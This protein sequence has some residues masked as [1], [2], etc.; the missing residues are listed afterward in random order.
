MTEPERLTLRWE[1]L[2]IVIDNRGQGARGKGIE[3]NIEI[4]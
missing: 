4:D 1:A 3:G 2:Q